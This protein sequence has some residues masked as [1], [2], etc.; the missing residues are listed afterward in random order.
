VNKNR[1]FSGGERKQRCFHRVPQSSKLDVS[2][3]IENA[4]Q[5]LRRETEACDPCQAVSHGKER[6]TISIVFTFSLTGKLGCC[7]DSSP[8]GKRKVKREKITL[9]S[10]IS[11]GETG[12]LS[13]RDPPFNG[14]LLCDN[15][16]DVRGDT[17]CSL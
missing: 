9:R 3:G 15:R 14:P 5:M 17:S 10:S 2:I 11:E 8:R 13:E 7:F 1:I 6:A 4:F 16:P 12:G